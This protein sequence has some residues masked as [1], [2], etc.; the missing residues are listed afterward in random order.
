MPKEAIR[1]DGGK[2]TITFPETVVTDPLVI[3]L[4]DGAADAVRPDMYD[5]VIRFGSYAYLEDRI[6][7]FLGRTADQVN[8]EFEY[9]KLLFDRHQRS[10]LTPEK[11]AIAESAVA[12]ALEAVVGSRGWDD[13]ITETGGIGGALDDGANKT[14]DVVAR[15]GGPEGPCLAIEVKFDKKV[16][17]GEVDDAKHQNNRADTAW[18]QIV[19]AAANREAGLA[20]IVVDHGSA[21]SSVLAAVEDV[22]WLEGAGLVVMVDA[23]RGDFRNLVVA[24]T[25]ARSLL[26]AAA[27]PDL[28][29]ELLAVVVS[30]AL[31]EVKRCLGVRGH[32][33]KIVKASQELLKDLGQ[34][35]AALESILELLG[36]IDADN[37]LGAAELFTLHRGEDV[38]DAIARAEK[39][40]PGLQDG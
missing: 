11:G 35:E 9:L 1:I 34:S 28:Q 4:F 5:R 37:P 17:L 2:K 21:S 7:A 22:A 24:Y 10:M 38:R 36:S 6:G 26:L 33:D 39:A 13:V 20:M 27:R 12:S 32:V 15:I 30:R 14:G 31:T 18:S 23:E 29:P 40:L 16:T 8:A 25:F 3:A 19:E